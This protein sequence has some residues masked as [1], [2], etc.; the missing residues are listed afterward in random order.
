MDENGCVYI[1]GRLKRIIIRH[2][3][4]KIFPRVIEQIIMRE[5]SITTCCVVGK[6]DTKHGRGQVPVAFIVL[7]ERKPQSVEKVEAICKLELREN[8]IPSKYIIVE[9]LPLTPNGKVDYRKL[10]E[11]TKKIPN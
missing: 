3:G 2:D 8:Y 5:E 10:E 1:D 11:M 7:N 6:S 9:K 4:M